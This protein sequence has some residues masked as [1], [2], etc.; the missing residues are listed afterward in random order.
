MFCASLL[1][2]SPAIADAVPAEFVG[3]LRNEALAQKRKFFTNNC[4]GFRHSRH[5][6]VL[7]SVHTGGS[8]PVGA[9]FEV[10]ASSRSTCRGRAPG[11]GFTDDSLFKNAPPTRM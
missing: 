8:R 10:D 1:V 5:R 11:V 4:K 2:G 7:C 3:T 9:D 6:P